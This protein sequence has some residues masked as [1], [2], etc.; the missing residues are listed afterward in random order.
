MKYFRTA[1]EKFAPSLALSLLPSLSLFMR[2]LSCLYQPR[3]FGSRFGSFMYKVPGF[4]LLSLFVLS[5]LRKS[6]FGLNSKLNS[7]QTESSLF[8]GIIHRCLKRNAFCR[9]A[10]LI[11]VWVV[12]RL[13]NLFDKKKKQIRVLVMRCLMSVYQRVSLCLKL[14]LGQLKH[15][16]SCCKSRNPTTGRLR[17]MNMKNSTY[18]INV[19]G[20]DSVLKIWYLFVSPSVQ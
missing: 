13:M 6:N 15:L 3:H 2:L 19:L 10:L 11:V 18:S 7:T 12:R 1:L 4:E 17:M 8:C 5:S 16:S 9:L 20:S 14:H